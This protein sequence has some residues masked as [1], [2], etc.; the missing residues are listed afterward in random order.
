LR[1]AIEP[2]RTPLFMALRSEPGR[3]SHDAS[4]ARTLRAR[5]QSSRKR[6]R[7]RLRRSPAPAW[8]GIQP[9]VGIRRVDDATAP[10][11]ERPL[12][13]SNP[14]MQLPAT[15]PGSSTVAEVRPDE[16]AFVFVATP[17]RRSTICLPR[18]RK[19][20]AGTG[21]RP[22]PFTGSRS[23]PMHRTSRRCGPRH[24]RPPAGPDSELVA[25]HSQ[26]PETG[27]P[28]RNFARY[29]RIAH[30]LAAGEGDLS[31]PKNAW[32]G[33]FP[34]KIATFTHRQ[35]PTPAVHR[36]PATT[37]RVPGMIDAMRGARCP[38][39]AAVPRR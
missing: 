32:A 5:T 17:T 35:G 22:V 15:D 16:Q 25:D 18:P 29:G 23:T 2:A 13:V 21:R 34:G 1:T 26:C 38:R 19:N 39:R 28:R 10:T 7:R 30:E 12:P 14:R 36:G 9:S 31:L 33:R 11:R 4:P 8:P 3:A 37:P 20:P 24:H 27:G 6:G